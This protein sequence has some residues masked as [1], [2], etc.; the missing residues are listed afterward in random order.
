MSGKSHHVVPSNGK[1]KV[2]RSGADRA[3]GVFTSESEAT[4]RAI[5]IARSQGTELFIHG[6]NGRI[7][8]VQN[9][10]KPQAPQK[11]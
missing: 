5:T 1:W 4:S 7:R 8:S 3:T 9:F 10:K 11:G 6:T 2:V